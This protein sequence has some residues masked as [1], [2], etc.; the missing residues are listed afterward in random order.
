VHHAD[1]LLEHLLR[2]SKVSDDPILHRTNGLDIA[3]H[4]AQHLFGLVA[5]GFDHFFAA[6]AALVSD[7]HYGGLIQN[8]A[9]A[10]DVNQGIGS[11]QVNGD[12]LGEVITKKS[13]H[14]NPAAK[15]KDNKANIPLDFFIV[16][17]DAQDLEK[18]ARLARLALSDRERDETLPALQSVLNW[19]GE[20]SRAPTAGVEPMAHPHDVGLRLRADVAEPLPARDDLMASAPQTA[21]GLFIV[22]RVVE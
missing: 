19:V 17:L 5:N 9:L 15:G 12:V 2:H 18:L 14:E 6:V 22:P 4:L 21:G 16:N 1:E 11:A 3:R 20:L 7:G 8:D 13:K 10:L